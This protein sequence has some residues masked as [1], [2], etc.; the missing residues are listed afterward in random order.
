MLAGTNTLSIS[1]AHGVYAGADRQHVQGY[2]ERPWWVGSAGG[3][4]KEELL[5][6]EEEPRDGSCLFSNMTQIGL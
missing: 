4:G 5:L 1:L 6:E 3:L 2:K